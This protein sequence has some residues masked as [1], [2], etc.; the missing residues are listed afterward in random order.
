M[1]VEAMHWAQE[2]FGEAQLGDVRRT[3]RLVRL[4][5][6][7]LED[8]EGSLPRQTQGN[9]SDLKGAYRLLRADG[10]SHEAI[11]QPYWQ[12]SRDL[13]QQEGAEV[14]L[15]HDDTE[16]DYGYQSSREG[17]GAI[18]NGSHRG[19]LVHSVLAVVPVGAEERVLGLVAQ[20]PWVRQPAE[21]QRDGRKQNSR[22]RR[23]R[24]RESAV[25]WHSVEQV[26][27]PPA[28]QRWIHVGD[29]YA[30]MLPFLQSCQ[31]LGTAF[32]VRAAQNRR[33]WP[34][35]EP[36]A[37]VEHLLDEARSWPAQATGTVEVASEHERRAR[38]AQVQLSW[39]SV[40]LRET[41]GH[42]RP[43]R[44]SQPMRVQ[45]VRV[46]EPQPPSQAQGQRAHAT[47]SKHGHGRRTREL[48]Q[49]P[50]QQTV[51]PLE[52]ILLSSLPIQDAQQAWHIVRAY[53]ARWM[54]E[55]FHRGLKSG[56][57]LEWARLQEERS[58]ENLLAICSP[59]AVHLLSLREL[60][61]LHA[62][63]PASDW[64]S[65]QEVQVV[66]SQ[67]QVPVET[68]T[69]RQYVRQVARLGGFLG[70][71]SDGEPGWQTLWQG[72]MRVQWVAA[73][74]RFASAASATSPP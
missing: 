52:W 61:R 21:R 41:D 68:M 64:V 72:W 32:V 14:L 1:Q 71:K 27:R 10:V 19:L 48:G 16:L 60:A 30:D 63:E 4:A 67:A 39:G 59:I 73:G 43:K 31:R 35:P 22:Q 18:G 66:A 38:Q 8:P 45:V 13:A 69:M 36:Q 51:E 3:R 70:R 49:H 53:Q 50:E 34:E 28:G 55:D 56:C 42:G 15:V 44:G 62:E 11:S 17:L 40:W 29:R 47:P 57:R 20:V 46:W 5:A 24:E 33:L 26:G 58:L 74:M 25:W 23:E 9:W 6:Q 54:I 65:P 2:T 12:H 37:N 7:M